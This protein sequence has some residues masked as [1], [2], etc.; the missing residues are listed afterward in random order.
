[1][2]VVTSLGELESLVMRAG[3]GGQV[4]IRWSRGPAADL[5]QGR[6]Q[7]SQDELTG[8]CMPGL[9]ASSL[10]PE[11]W[12]GSRSLRLWLAR[13]LIDYCHLRNARGPGVRPWVLVGEEQGRGPDNEPLV[14]CRR[15]LAWL[16]EA[17][18]AEAEQ[19]V[20]QAPAGGWRP[21]NRQG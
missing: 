21:L 7:S 13:R 2:P 9:S 17:V 18:L 16:D 14:R 8:V 4:F 12:W 15:P 11:P 3:S 1:M 19:V 10:R 6:E 5:G 20:A